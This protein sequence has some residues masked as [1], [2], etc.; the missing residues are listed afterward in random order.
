[1]CGHSEEMA[2][3]PKTGQITVYGCYMMYDPIKG[4]R[5]MIAFSRTGGNG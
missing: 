2:F 1:M 5:K 4:V 3:G